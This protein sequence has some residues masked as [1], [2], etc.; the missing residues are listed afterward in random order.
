M[1]FKLTAVAAILAAT[2]FAASAQNFPTK[3]V[4][5]VVPFPPGGGVDIV[6]RVVGPK[7][8]AQY[9][10]QVIVENRS[11]AAGI[12][13]TEYTA[14]SAPDGYTW[15]IC[16][17][18]NLAV[19]KHLYAKM[20]VD[21]LKDLAA[22]TQVVDVHFVMVAHP[23]LPAKTVPQLIALAKR[24]PTGDIT[25][26]SSGAG[27]APH[28][29]GALFNR[30]AGVQ[31]TH[32]PYKG[33]GPSFADLL[34]GHVSLTFDSML[35]SLPY[36][37]DKKLVALGVLGAKRAAALPDV[38]TIAEQGVKGYE[39]TNWFGLVVPAATP[40]DLI[41][42]VHGDFTRVLQEKEIREKIAGMGADVVANS[43]EDFAKF[44]RNES[45]KWARVIKE[46][47]IT[48]N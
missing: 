10:Q 3:P 35:Q 22:V 44:W 8:A 4:R 15:A 43:P 29:G 37:R 27:G 26:S 30:L 31:L 2:A 14:R 25:Y 19:N 48:V 12:I 17:L 36:I 46:A 45:D 42:R 39:L 6:A 28:L 20:A 18:G 41:A 32:V 9:G 7:L 47:K 11:G 13:G 1:Q 33:S 16:T 23:S 5:I 24:L 34:G 21:P 40:K 38:P